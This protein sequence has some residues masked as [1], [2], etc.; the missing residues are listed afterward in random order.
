M[1]GLRVVLEVI[2]EIVCMFDPVAPIDW[3]KLQ[4]VRVLILLQGYTA[5]AYASI[6]YNSVTLRRSPV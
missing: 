5:R 2:D 6:T 3:S 4:V 1:A